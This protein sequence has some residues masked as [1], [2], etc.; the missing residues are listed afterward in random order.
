MA[1]SKTP[2]ISE[3]LEEREH[4]ERDDSGLELDDAFHILKNQRRRHVL[5]YIQREGTPVTLS[6]LA[7]YVA[8][9]EEDTTVEALS[10]Q[11]RKRVYVG[12][13]QSH[14]P[15][16]DDRNVIVYDKDRGTVEAGP[17]L[18][19]LRPY[20]AG[21]AT[22]SGTWYRYYLLSAVLGW[23]LLAAYLLGASAYGLTGELILS[24]VLV[25]ITA[26]TVAHVKQASSDGS[27]SVT[28][29]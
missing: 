24:V 2:Q 20:L 1:S 5:A 25:I 16:M 26:V 7:E 19:Y 8:A 10:S 14:L 4:R 12:L 28:H 15:M 21:E 29:D 23:A 22:E 11:Q 9:T 27:K 3:S 18:Q 17:N 13:Y 6:E